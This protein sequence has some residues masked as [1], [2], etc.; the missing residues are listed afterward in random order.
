V[1]ILGALIMLY[2]RYFGP[3]PPDP[4][5]GVR[6]SS[7]AEGKS[8]W[9]W[10]SLKAFT[11]LVYVFMFAPIVVV[12]L[13]SFNAADYGSFPLRGFS[14]RWFVKLAEN[15]TIVNAFV[16]SAVLGGLT[17]MIGTLLGL[18]AAMA[19]VH[20]EV[21]GRKIASALIIAPLLVPETVLAV[22][23]LLLLREL[24]LPRTYFLL[25]AGHVLITLPFAFLVIRARLTGLGR[26]YG[27]AAASLGAGPFS[28]FREITLPLCFPAIVA[29]LMFAFTISFDNLTASLFLAAGRHR[30]RA[31]A[32]ILDA[33]RFGQPGNQCAG[34]GHDRDYNRPVV[35]CNGRRKQARRLRKG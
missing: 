26:S 34:H 27:E 29:A 20:H 24:D 14:F 25:L 2:N 11:L 30:N 18:L 31:H 6:G 12:V 13:L 5:I 28:V 15:R 17:A 4:G 21:K 33:E 8:S 9:G 19:L 23:L 1:I 22:G 7:A 3:R 35:R 16:T 32:G 10:R